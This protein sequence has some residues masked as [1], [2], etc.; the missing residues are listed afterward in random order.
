MSSTDDSGA[1]RRGEV[2]RRRSRLATVQPLPLQIERLRRLRPSF[3]LPAP[4]V[5]SI[6]NARRAELPESF[7]PQL[8]TRVDAPPDG[9]GWLHEIKLDGYR[10]LARV[11]RNEVRLVSRNGRDW[12]ARLPALEKALA[13]LGFER[14]LLDGELVALQSDGTSS[15][16]LL[17]EALAARRT[18]GLV[19]AAFDLLH[20]DG[21]DLTGVELVTRKRLLKSLLA[22]R[23][24]IGNR[25]PV[26]YVHHFEGKGAELF[27]EVRR[28]DLEGIVSKRRSSRY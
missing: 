15:F 8:A 6:P 13:R 4:D 27:E 20:L 10:L 11:N 12:T 19:S 28:L 7:A 25:G 18:R 3:D 21:Y 22:S 23:G 1:E 16:R 2:I 24:I 9:E 5:G 17:Q 26:R 14:A